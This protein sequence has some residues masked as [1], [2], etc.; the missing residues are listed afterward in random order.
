V[1][2]LLLLLLQLGDVVVEEVK[3]LIVSADMKNCPRADMEVP[4]NTNG[5]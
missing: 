2:C 5:Q 1:I 3:D 4:T